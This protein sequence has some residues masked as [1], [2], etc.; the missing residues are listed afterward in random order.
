MP[1]SE[2]L[3]FHARSFI[4]NY[5]RSPWLGAPVLV[6]AFAMVTRIRRLPAAERILP[7]AFLAGFALTTIHVYKFVRFFYT[8]A[9]FAYLSCGRCIAMIVE[10]LARRPETVRRA[11][12]AT[13]GVALGIALVFGT[14]MTDVRTRYLSWM[15]ADD[16]REV[17][18]AIGDV[19]AR[20]RGTALLGVWNQLSFPLLEWDL[21]LQKRNRDAESRPKNAGWP[22][23]P[24]S[25]GVRDRLAG[26]A[27]I[28]RLMVLD[29]HPDAPAWHST[30]D[31]ENPGHAA[32]VEGLR[33]DARF[34]L[35]EV[36]TFPATGYALYV[37]RTR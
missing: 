8:I 10:R 1:L 21:M 20:S 35:E 16:V 19:H 17:M 22:A 7:V 3:V 6:A 5:T 28:E 25:E 13:A 4:L 34:T 11:S 36:R 15:P 24:T 23:L 27:E 37:F 9:P 14:D 12:L 30:F 32:I 33:R 18:R 31:K 29:L 2:H 26:D